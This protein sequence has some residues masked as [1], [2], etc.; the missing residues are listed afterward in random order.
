MNYNLSILAQ[1]TEFQNQQFGKKCIGLQSAIEDMKTKLKEVFPRAKEAVRKSPS[2]E[3]HHTASYML[4]KENMTKGYD[5]AKQALAAS[6]QDVVSQ[7]EDMNIND[8]I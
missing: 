8:E 7:L 4:L 1:E 5:F 2:L 6:F 3:L